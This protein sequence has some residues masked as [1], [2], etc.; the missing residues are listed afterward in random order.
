MTAS[1]TSPPRDRSEAC[2]AATADGRNRERRLAAARR[3]IASRPANV[4]G[5][6]R[7]HRVTASS[8]GDRATAQVRRPAARSQAGATAL[9]AKRSAA[10]PQVRR[11]RRASRA[12]ST[13]RRATAQVRRPAARSQAGRRVAPAAASLAVRGGTS[14][15]AGRR[16]IGGGA[17]DRA[18]RSLQAPRGSVPGRAT[19]AC[20]LLR[21]GADGRFRRFAAPAWAGASRMAAATKP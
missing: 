9:A 1:S 4:R 20:C 12:S 16:A 13:A 7:V 18:R 21:D 6:R 2:R 11:R 5:G 3:A 17:D 10:R 8:T 14:S 15:P 19:S